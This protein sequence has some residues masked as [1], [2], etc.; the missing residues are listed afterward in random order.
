M[1]KNLLNVESGAEDLRAS[2]AL[3]TTTWR[4]PRQ[5]LGTTCANQ[6]IGTQ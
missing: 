3:E 2:S 1:R 5:R 4:I 6:A